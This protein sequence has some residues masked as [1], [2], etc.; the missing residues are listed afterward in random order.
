MQILSIKNIRAKR[1]ELES[2]YSLLTEFPDGKLAE[3]IEDVGFKCTLC[4]KCCT[5]EFNDHVFLLDSDIDRAKR[6]DPSSIVPAPYFELCDQDGNF[7]VSGYSLRCQKNGDCI[8]LKDN[9]CTIYSD[10]FSICRVYPFMLHRE[11]DEDGVKDF[12][13]ISGLNL[14][15]EYNHPVE[16]KDA[17][18]IA[19][20]TT[21][22]EKE[23]LEK[24]IAFYS[25]V[26]K[27]F[28]ENGL[29]PVRRIYDRKMREFSADLPVTVYVFSKGNFERN[30]VKKSDYISKT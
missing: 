2:E 6:I 19:E 26:L 7:Y 27:L 21:A 11:E 24:E 16:K 12:R 8:F 15:G 1:E 14:H 29:K 3:I 20:R 23:F 5:K 25:A 13:Q 30:T 9:R 10:R 4:G 22:Y 17:E 28:E 18:E